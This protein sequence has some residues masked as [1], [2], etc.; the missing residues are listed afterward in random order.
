MTPD[1][2]KAVVKHWGTSV[3]ACL[4]EG[5]PVGEV[6]PALLHLTA[7]CLQGLIGPETSRR[8]ILALRDRLHKE[9]TDLAYRQQKA[10]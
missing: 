10:R 4:N 9:M 6:V 2:A 3:D 7:G 1:Q 5:I 8:D